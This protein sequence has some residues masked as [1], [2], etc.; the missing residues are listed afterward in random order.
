MSLSSELTFDSSIIGSGLGGSLA[1]PVKN[2]PNV[3]SKGSFLE[4]Y[5]FLLPNLV[6]AFVVLAG[7]AVGILFLEETHEEKK[8]HRDWGLEMGRWLLGKDQC[9]ETEHDRYSKH[10]E[11]QLEETV[12]LIQ[13]DEHPPA[14]E[15]TESGEDLRLVE[16][17]SPS[18]LES[19]TG[20]ATARPK[21]VGNAFTKQVMLNV[22]AYGILA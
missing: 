11:A 2:Y 19:D 17:V 10:A 18:I 6:S 14:Y 5:P 22:V 15:A 16:G 8:H 21:E 1:E 9:S 13:E 20:V 12:A 3:F 7:L 4:T